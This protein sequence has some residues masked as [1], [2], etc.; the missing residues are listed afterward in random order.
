MTGH[1]CIFCYSSSRGY[2]SWAYICPLL[3]FTMIESVFMTFEV[4]S[5]HKV[6]ACNE[7]ILIVGT[8]ILFTIGTQH[9]NYEHSITITTWAGFR[10][11]QEAQ[12]WKNG[13]C[14]YRKN[15]AW[16]TLLMKVVISQWSKYI[17]PVK[18]WVEYRAMVFV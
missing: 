6:I 15:T 14:Q 3:Q 2:Y 10:L 13:S 16:K 17:N 11:K 8:N 9:Y 18:A 1:F 12:T 7:K 4:L 5:W